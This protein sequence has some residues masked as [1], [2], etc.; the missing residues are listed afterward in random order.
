MPKK[1]I[2]ITIFILNSSAYSQDRIRYQYKKRESI[3][4]GELSLK[5][6]VVSPGDLSSKKRDTRKLKFK[7]P[8]RK[9]FDDFMQNDLDSSF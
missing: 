6:N 9:H 5:G 2:F 1:L 4:L 3:D 8:V 7:I